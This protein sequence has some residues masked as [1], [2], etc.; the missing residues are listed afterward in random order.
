MLF[1]LALAQPWGIEQAPVRSRIEEDGTGGATLAGLLGVIFDEINL[2]PY[3]TARLC[4]R[5]ARAAA[6]L[7]QVCDHLKARKR[8]GPVSQRQRGCCCCLKKTGGDR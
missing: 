6:Q 8:H 2:Q 1:H 5:W 3:L 7:V 4:S